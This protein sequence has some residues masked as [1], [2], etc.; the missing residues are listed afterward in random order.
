[1]R[2]IFCKN[3][4]RG[5]RA[6][7]HIVPESLGN[8]SHTL[9]TGVVC[10]KCNNY[11]ASKVEKPFLEKLEI[12]SLR[13]HEAVPN[14][15]GRIPS[16]RGIMGSDVQVEVVRDYKSGTTSV[17]VPEAGFDSIRSQK[18]GMLIIPAPTLLK[19]DRIVS[20][21]IAKVALEALAQRIQHD[22]D[23]LEQMIE[24]PQLDLLRNHA[25][26]G[27]VKEWP[28]SIRKIYEISERWEDQSQT[29]YQIVH[30]FDFLFTNEN[31]VYF[32]MAIFGHEYCINLGGPELEGWSDW[33]N[34]NEHS[35][36]LHSGKNKN[37]DKKL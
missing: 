20:R 24:N 9:Y 8:K 17:Y 11:F 16:L 29:G 21:F 25:R 13:F 23:L 28:V 35:S 19:P 36:P 6:V 37:L 7:E 26:K 31:E 22:N 2:C 18:N 30:E 4:S 33:L 34:Q 27:E 15:R 32:V 5:S 10:D 1:M 3:D 12:Q 14:K